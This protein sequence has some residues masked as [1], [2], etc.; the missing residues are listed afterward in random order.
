MEQKFVLHVNSLI[1]NEKDE[2]L[3][4]REAKQKNFR[5]WNLPGGHLDIGESLTGGAAREVLEETGLQVKYSALCKIYNLMKENHFL[6]F[7]FYADEFS[8][9]LIP[10]EG[11]I[12]EC[13]WFTEDEI[14][15][16]PDD[17]M[18]NAW[19]IKGLLPLNKSSFLP[20]SAIDDHLSA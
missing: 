11:E 15:H 14:L 19:K 20:L 7:V 2:I 6:Q 4:V 16:I 5:L 13:Q 10:Q 9:T 1:Q 18:L 12:L 3:L 17:Q 8:G